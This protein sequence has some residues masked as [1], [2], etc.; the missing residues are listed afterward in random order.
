M[1]VSVWQHVSETIRFNA[2]DSPLA[3]LSVKTQAE[4][5]NQPSSLGSLW[6]AVLN[7]CQLA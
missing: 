1:E 5:E 7:L 3:G 4:G 2:K 6:A